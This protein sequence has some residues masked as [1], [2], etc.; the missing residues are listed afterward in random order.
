MVTFPLNLPPTT[1][2]PD[3][4][5]VP[6]IVPSGCTSTVLPLGNVCV[7]PSA[8][9]ALRDQGPTRP[10]SAQNAADMRMNMRMVR[11][12]ALSVAP[13]RGY[14]RR[15]PRAR[16]AAAPSV[17]V[18][19]FLAFPPPISPRVGFFLLSIIV[20]SRGLVV[21]RGRLCLWCIARGVMLRCEIPRASR[22]VCRRFGKKLRKTDHSC[23]LPVQDDAMQ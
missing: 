3:I 10:E 22:F 5:Q 2:L 23:R 18:R 14:V 8:A 7:Y 20:P 4:T 17:A 13:G 12:L 1:A 16:R 11:A 9:N 15:R 19:P 21:E 6:V